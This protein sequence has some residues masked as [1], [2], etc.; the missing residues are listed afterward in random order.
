MCVQPPLTAGG[1]GCTLSLTHWA[2]LPLAHTRPSCLFTSHHLEGL[3]NFVTP[4][5]LHTLPSKYFIEMFNEAISL[6]NLCDPSINTI[7]FR[8]I[9]MYSILIL[10]F[11]RFSISIE[12]GKHFPQGN[13][14]IKTFSS[15]GFFSENL[16]IF[17]LVCLHKDVLYLYMPYKALNDKDFILSRVEI[18][19][20]KL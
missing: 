17:I 8:E 4:G 15:K 20:S 2:A 6:I 7:L 16:N 19:W 1:R 18:K 10:G 14:T 11:L 13:P 5:H 12:H 3:S 9:F